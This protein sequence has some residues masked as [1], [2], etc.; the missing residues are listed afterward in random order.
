MAQENN[1][2]SSKKGKWT[3]RAFIV[4]GGVV[5]TGLVVGVGGNMYITKKIKE[6]SHDGFGPGNSLNAWVHIAAD[7]TITLAV[8]RSEMG[9]GVYTS[10]P[11]LIAE[12]LEVDVAKI[13][14]VHPQPESP[15]ANTF[16]LTGQP[17]D[18]RGG[19]T[20]MEKIASFLPV[21]GTGGSTTISDGYDNMRAAGATAREALVTAAANQ[22][23]ISKS[24]CFAEDG[25]VINKST[26]EKLTYGALAEAAAQ[27]KLD[28][29]PKLKE[30]K[31]FK[32]LGKPVRRLDIPDKV[33]GQAEF[34]IDVRREGMRFASI[35]HPEYLGGIITNVDNKEEVESMP[36]VEKVIVLG[37]GQGVAVVANNTWRAKNGALALEVTQDA[38]GAEGLNSTMISEKMKSIIENDEMIATPEEEGDVT[39]ALHSDGMT[40]IES[41]YEV[42][43]L[44][45][46]TMEPLNC[47]A[48][49]EEDKA[50]VWV[51]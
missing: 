47:T 11:M 19:L 35:R 2:K 18:I 14:I 27:V 13:R 9:Q 41:Y 17:R 46:A 28:G 12:E 42:P 25:H 8:P 50:T 43:Y 15:Y 38:Q 33:T 16:L 4:T 32:L 20:L 34:G 22:W 7:N 30:Q 37:D 51:G 3:R 44:A 31:D 26:N 40:V 23:G 49:V 39:K 24:D 10:V 5:G 48:L 29:I 6:Y 45:Q 36:G 21:V 1:Q